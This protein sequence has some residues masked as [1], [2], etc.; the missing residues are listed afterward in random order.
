MLHVKCR[1]SSASRAVGLALALA[2]IQEFVAAQATSAAE[3]RLD[4][5]EYAACVAR[6]EADD[7][8][9]NCTSDEAAWQ[10]DVL[11]AT[12]QQVMKHLSP[13]EQRL[14]RDGERAWIKQ[15]DQTC[16]VD[17]FP[18][19]ATCNVSE[20]EARTLYLTKLAHFAK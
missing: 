2:L 17:H 18:N 11:N 13:G 9:N 5:P 10:N 15:R 20:T 7:N 6:G 12:Y 19:V 4:S 3:H 1:F 16:L 14:L 8:V